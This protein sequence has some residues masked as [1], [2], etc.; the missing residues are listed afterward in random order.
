M[1]TNSILPKLAL[2][3]IL[4][5][6]PSFV[7]GD[8]PDISIPD[9]DIA[10]IKTIDSVEVTGTNDLGGAEDFSIHDSKAIG[11]FVKLLTSERYTA[12]P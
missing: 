11:Q 8:T 12:V 3:A 1:R 4:V 5:I 2:L 9:Q 7:R 10:L 6:S